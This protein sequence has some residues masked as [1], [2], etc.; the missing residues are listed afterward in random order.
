MQDF[1]KASQKLVDWL[2]QE[3]LPLWAKSGFNEEQGASYERLLPNG[4]PDL[5]SNVRLRV[6]ARQIFVYAVAN[7]MGWS[8]VG[9]TRAESILAFMDRVAKHPTAESGYTHLLDSHFE[10]ID[11]KQDLY[12]HAFYILANISCYRAFGLRSALKKARSLLD[13]I[14]TR[15]K[16]SNG[17]W[18]EGD[19]EYKL[20]RQNP[21]MHLFEAFLTAY[22]ATKEQYWLDRATG[23]FQLFKNY[24]YDKDTAV[25]REFFTDDWELPAEENKLA[26]QPGHMMEWVWLLCWYSDRSKE[27]VLQYVNAL[28]D[29]ALEIGRC[30]ESGLLFDEVYISGEVKEPTKRCW[31]I[32]ELIK[33]SIALVLTGRKECI[34]S[35]TEAIELLLRF[36]IDPAAIKG[37]YV[38]QLDE[39]NKVVANHTLASTLYHLVT[40]AVVADCFCKSKAR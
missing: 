38:D 17:G 26:V 36:Y 32:T 20:R 3:S 18:I 4:Q 22:D 35:A 27:D 13:Y 19:Y 15:F 1:V 12:D 31:V 2:K 23:I 25:V 5:S 34:G 21:H 24:F 11:A 8:D 6:Q 39:H 28:Y 9:R 10:V 37:A 16:S 7:H 33:A 29:R 14:D 30:K 40:T